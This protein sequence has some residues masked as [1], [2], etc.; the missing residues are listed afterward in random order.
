[1]NREKTAPANAE[2]KTTP[3]G[4]KIL[5]MGPVPGGRGGGG[6]GGVFLC[7]VLCFGFAVDPP[8]DSVGCRKWFVFADPSIH[9]TQRVAT[10]GN[11]APASGVL[12]GLRGRSRGSGGRRQGFFFSVVLFCAQRK[13]FFGRIVLCVAGSV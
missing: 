8:V 9:R 11:Q 6:G 4:T 3:V 10:R 1:M 13:F 2:D 7:W 5:K 12:Q